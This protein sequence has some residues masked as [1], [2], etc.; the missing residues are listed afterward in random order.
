MECYLGLHLA[1]DAQVAA[2]QYLYWPWPPGGAHVNNF[3]ETF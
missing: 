1:T 2:G 3:K